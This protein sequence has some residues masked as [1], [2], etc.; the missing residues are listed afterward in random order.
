MHTA[1]TREM[2][3]IIVYIPVLSSFSGRITVWIAASDSVADS[4]LR[5]SV[6]TDGGSGSLA[7]EVDGVESV[8][9]FAV[10]SEVSELSEGVAVDSDDLDVSG[11]VVSKGFVVSAFA[12]VSGAAVD[13]GAPVASGASDVWG[14]IVVTAGC[15]STAVFMSK[16]SK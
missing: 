8:F 11:A 1:I 12:V 4:A 14:A 16:L 5:T 9:F 6:V 7:L 2:I 15:V 3:I 13:S 10:V